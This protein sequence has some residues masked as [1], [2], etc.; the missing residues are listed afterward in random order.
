MA[1]Q[2]LA[3]IRSLSK[4]Q[5][6]FRRLRDN[7]WSGDLAPGA[8]LREAHIAKQLNV[9]Q[10][11]VREALLQLEHFGLVVRVPDHGTTVTKLA[12]AEILQ[13]NQVRLNL[14]ELAFSLAIKRITPEM[15]AEL[16]GHLARMEELAAAGDL[17][18]VAEEDFNFHRAV[19][20]ASGNLILSQTLERLCTALYA[21][22]SLKRHTAG[23]LPETAAELHRKL[24]DGLLSGDEQAALAG[25]REHLQPS[26]VI[27]ESISE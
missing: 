4:S 18:G 13:T 16:R 11:P 14:E 8:P 23:E 26:A 15:E 24:L 27:P 20:K 5:E 22:V 12:R 21:F 25:I 17:F 6:V 7:I 2:K 9:S 1:I 19:W 10:V 3:P